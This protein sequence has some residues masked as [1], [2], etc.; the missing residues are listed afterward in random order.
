MV[1]PTNPSTIDGNPTIFCEETWDW[2]PTST[3]SRTALGLN[4]P[5][6]MKLNNNNAQIG[7]KMMQMPFLLY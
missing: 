4:L 7:H 2:N 1:T 5:T 6:T 3:A